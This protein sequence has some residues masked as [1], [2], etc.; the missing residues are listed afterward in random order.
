MRLINSKSEKLF[1][2]I[3]TLLLLVYLID[4]V[5]VS[6]LR[7]QSASVNSQ[8]RAAEHQLEKNRAIISRRSMIQ[9]QYQQLF[10]SNTNGAE[11]RLTRQ[12]DWFGGIEA[13]GRGN[14]S[15]R[16]ITPLPDVDRNT[17]LWQSV[18]ISFEGTMDGVSAFAFNL[19]T[20]AQRSEIKSMR[21]RA[22]AER[23][24][25]LDCFVVVMRLVTQ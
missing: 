2:L 5:L 14:V 13:A 7:E 1:V 10:P 12:E 3:L 24:G 17:Y 20:S 6:P 21:I 19:L 18:E 25:S 4:S 9:Q 15:I 22:S 16:G 23:P 8:I 11:D